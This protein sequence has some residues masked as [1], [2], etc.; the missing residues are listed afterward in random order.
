MLFLALNTTFTSQQQH[1]HSIF[2]FSIL[3]HNN[4]FTQQQQP[5]SYTTTTTFTITFTQQPLSYTTTTTSTTTFL[6]NNNN[7]HN[8]FPTQQ[9]QLFYATTTTNF[10][11]NN[12]NLHNN[13]YSTTDFLHNNNNLHNHFPTQQQ[14]HLRPYNNRHDTSSPLRTILPWSAIF[15]PITS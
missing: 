15:T 2:T 7:L 1:F 6:R 9:Q 8:H 4:F 5:I 11:H 3:S 10:L 12:N 13:L 14:Q